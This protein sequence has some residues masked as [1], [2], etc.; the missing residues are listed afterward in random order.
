MEDDDFLKSF[1]KSD[2][3]SDFVHYNIL[4]RNFSFNILGESEVK[5]TSFKI[6]EKMQK[7]TDIENTE[8]HEETPPI[9]ELKITINDNIIPVN[10]IEA[11]YIKNK[12]YETLSD[13][14]ENLLEK[15]KNDIPI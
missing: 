13:Q 8:K 2:S 11:F 10:S 15:V 3:V 6:Y 9:S 7:T 1:Y 14:I 12:E 4:D 5:N